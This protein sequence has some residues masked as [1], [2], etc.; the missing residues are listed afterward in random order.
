M[1]PLFTPYAPWAQ[2][3]LLL[4]G[5]VCLPVLGMLGHEYQQQRLLAGQI[6]QA[7]KKNATLQNALRKMR[8]AGQRRRLRAQQ[9]EAAPSAVLMLDD[10]GS[11]LTPDVAILSIDIAPARHECRLTMNAKSLD[12]L[13]A[14]SEQLQ[15]I[16]ANV[17]LEK[18]LPSRDSNSE[19]PVGAAITLYFHQEASHDS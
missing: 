5:L 16:S 15:M 9:L 4:T 18:H 3:T 17:V 10:I 8:E 1:K 12:A 19:W 2:R 13:L 7:Q 11:V 14:F 6:V